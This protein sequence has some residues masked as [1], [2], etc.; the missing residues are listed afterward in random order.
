M[1]ENAIRSVLKLTEIIFCFSELQWPC[2]TS[3]MDKPHPAKP[4]LHT[5]LS[6]SRTG[7][8][9]VLW[10]QRLV[11]EQLQKLTQKTDSG[12][13]LRLCFPTCHLCVLGPHPSPWSVR[14][15]LLEIVHILHLVWVSRLCLEG[16]APC[17]EITYNL[18]RFQLGYVYCQL[19]CFLIQTNIIINRTILME[20]AFA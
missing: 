4:D 20:L 1:L 18:A 15:V 13:W 8:W 5:G 10:A 19:S 9:K 14:G 7:N 2:L 3:S 16:N 12:L 6:R 11:S 17:K